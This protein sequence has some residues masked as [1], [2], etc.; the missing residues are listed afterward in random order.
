MGEAAAQSAGGGTAG[1]RELERLRGQDLKW[2]RY[3]WGDAYRIGWDRVRGYW[4]RRRDG[5]GDEITA[6]DAWELSEKI[7]ADYK[8]RRV[9]RDLPPEAGTGAAGTAA[10]S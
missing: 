7:R 6:G 2:L 4:A 5:L 9:P 10:R 1:E 3:N 8:A